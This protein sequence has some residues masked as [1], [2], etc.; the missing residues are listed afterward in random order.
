MVSQLLK[1]SLQ[2]EEENILRNTYV[3]PVP[4]SYIKIFF[5]HTFYSVIIHHT[6]Q[7]YNGKRSLRKRKSVG[8]RSEIFERFLPARYSLSLE[9][10]IFYGMHHIAPLCKAMKQ[11]SFMLLFHSFLFFFL[12][13]IETIKALKIIQ[14]ENIK[15][16][17]YEQEEAV[18]S[19][20]AFLKIK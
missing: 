11:N 6:Q 13:F 10:A 19:L 5:S 15:I 4:S 9:S 3:I 7:E 8:I 2:N 12:T 16:N 20:R 14:W 17:E 18:I 1:G